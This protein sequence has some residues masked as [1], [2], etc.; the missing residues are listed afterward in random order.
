MNGV[1]NKNV[2]NFRVVKNFQIQCGVILI[3]VILNNN[4]NFSRVFLLVTFFFNLR[5]HIA[6]NNELTK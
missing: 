6:L 5:Y 3:I 2:E 1:T 4:E